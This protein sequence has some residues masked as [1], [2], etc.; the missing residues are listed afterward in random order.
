MIESAESKQRLLRLPVEL[1]FGLMIVSALHDRSR[2]DIF[3]EAAGDWLETDKNVRPFPRHLPVQQTLFRI[4]ETVDR[5]MRIS[6]AEA[7]TSIN[8][9]YFSAAML[10]FETNQQGFETIVPQLEERAARL[11]EVLARFE[12]ADS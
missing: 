2:A 11:G 12:L 10:W 3:I 4:P 8:N 7:D 6:A 1:N 5:G 9:T